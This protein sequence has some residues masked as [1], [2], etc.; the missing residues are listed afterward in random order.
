MGK[1]LV[2]TGE[3]QCNIEGGYGD[4]YGSC[5]SCT[6]LYC[7]KCNPTPFSC[8]Y[9]DSFYSRELIGTSCVCKA[10]HYEYYD[11]GKTDGRPLVCRRISILKI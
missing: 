5:K 3:C 2:S 9:C 4:Y 8:T 1:Y 7:L 10:L 11:I 6:M